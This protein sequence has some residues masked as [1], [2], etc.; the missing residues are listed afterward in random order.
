M[1]FWIKLNK[2][3]D[4]FPPK[5]IIPAKSDMNSINTTIPR[6]LLKLMHFQELFQFQR[7]KSN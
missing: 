6:P 3:I 5:T 7:I 2:M 4:F 1:L